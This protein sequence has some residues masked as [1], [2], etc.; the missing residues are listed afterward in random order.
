MREGYKEEEMERARIFS[1]K[2]SLTGLSDERALH[3]EQGSRT[4]ASYSR[5]K[6]PIVREMQQIKRERMK[7]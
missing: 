5:E 4:I 2:A 1:Q 3:E 6:E 7:N